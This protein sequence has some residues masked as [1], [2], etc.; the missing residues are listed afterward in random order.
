MIRLFDTAAGEVRELAL[1][2]P[3]TVSM[4]VCGP[5]VYGPPHLGHG[6]FSLV[7]DVLRRYLEWTG[8]D[9]TYVSNITDI[10]DNILERAE[11]E[12]RPWTDITERC[13]AVWWRAMDAIGVKRPTHDPHATAYVEKMVALVDRLVEVGMAYE[14]SDGVYFQSE[15]IEDYGLLAR[16]SLD[17]LRAGARVEANE[18]KLSSVDF[19]LWK[20]AKPSEPAWPSPWGDGR[21]GW[22]TECV[23]MSLE[24]LGEGFDIHGGGQDLAFPH[25][26]NERAQAVALGHRFAG[27]WV[28][29][30]FVE[31]G[32][33]KMSKSLGNFTNLLDLIDEHDPRAYRLLVLRSHYRAP[34]EISKE[35]V[36]DAEAALERLDRFAEKFGSVAVDPDRDALE[37]FRT[38]MDDDLGTP[39]AMALLFDL[40]KRANTSGDEA[41]AAAAFEIAGAVG[42]ELRREGGEIGEDALALARRRDEERDGEELGRRRR[43]ARRARRDGLRGGRHPGGHGASP[44]LTTVRARSAGGRGGRRRR[45][46]TSPERRRVAADDGAA[47]VHAGA[48]A[49]ADLDVVADPD[50]DL[51]AASSVGGSGSGAGAGAGAAGFVGV[52]GAPGFVGVDGVGA[53]G[54]AGT[55]GLGGPRPQA[56]TPEPDPPVDPMTAL[57]AAPP[58]VAPDVVPKA[59]GREPAARSPSLARRQGRARSARDG[60]VLAADQ[61]RRGRARR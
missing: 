1:R 15:R 20:K 10:D 27:H 28:H 61:R 31:V 46:S 8:L 56:A 7:F 42:L 50:G 57:P 21:P 16:Q 18:E 54:V 47:E 52:L 17:S 60:E 33:E 53:E 5:T 29:N 23:V 48:L 39:A 14:T 34:I 26:E 22:H 30:G 40:V 37:R 13:E 35:T 19:A 43:L 49:Q 4:Y 45:P 9:V 44:P 11:A 25:H 32:G 41:A 24:L 55:A 36:A 38:V 58:P 6:R 2:E 51:R 3:G 12:S 59:T